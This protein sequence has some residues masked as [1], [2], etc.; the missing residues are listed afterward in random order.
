MPVLT[1]AHGSNVLLV[2]SRH[3]A[4]GSGVWGANQKN[5]S[6]DRV[7]L[8]PQYPFE[9]PAGG[10]L[11][12]PERLKKDWKFGGFASP[13]ALPHSPLA[14]AEDLPDRQSRERDS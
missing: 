3:S 4:R 5:V 1:S 6:L 14:F 8:A 13:E 7:P 11:Q 10:V 12:V 2:A 9:R